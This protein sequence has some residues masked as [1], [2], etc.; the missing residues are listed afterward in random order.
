MLKQQVSL[1][2]P[3]PCGSGKKYKNC[4]LKADQREYATGRAAVAK[5]L[6][7]VIEFI[8]SD[9]GEEVMCVLGVVLGSV[10]ERYDEDVID[11]VIIECKE[12][13]YMT[14]HDVTAADYPLKRGETILDCYTAGN[15]KNLH[16]MA[17]DFLEG[18]K[19]SALSLY[20]VQKVQFRKSLTITDL[21][22]RKT[23]TVSASRLSETSGKGDTFFARAVP[24]GEEFLFTGAILPIDPYAIEDIQCYF[25]ELR[26]DAPNSKTLPWK[27]FLSKHWHLIPQYWLESMLVETRGPEMLNTDGDTI[28]NLRITFHLKPG[29]GFIVEKKLASI[30]GMIK[31]SRTGFDLVVDASKNDLTPLDSVSIASIRLSEDTVTIE[32]NSVNRG[33]LVESLLRKKLGRHIQ[34]VAREFI[35]GDPDDM[36]DENHEDEIPIELKELLIKE[37]LD[38]HY[39]RWLDMPIP[40]LHGKSPRQAAK[41]P[42]LRKLLI[43]LLRKMD[44]N[45]PVNGVVYDSAWLWDELK[46]KQR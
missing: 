44:S 34:T 43:F 46:L 39:T 36:D 12:L 15:G 18:W 31:S 26:E 2:A 8:K 4:C 45:P 24:I 22:S 30:P 6:L 19:H 13:L 25:R 40:A 37:A 10:Y 23:I 11:N 16:P 3:C 33:Y 38:K 14:L 20:E 7:D 42:K 41:D 32:V 17:L 27:R 29:S 5:T 28:E 1:I 9:F 21:F 35:S